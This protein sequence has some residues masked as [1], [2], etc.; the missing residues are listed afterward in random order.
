MKKNINKIIASLTLFLTPLI[1]KAAELPNP[2]KANSVP[3]LAR[4]VI[5]GL[6]GVA[7]AIALFYLV[8]G[9]I[10]WM[11]SQGNTDRIKKGKDT[12]VWAIF[13]LAAIF[14][15]YVVLD[16]LF[17]SLVQGASCS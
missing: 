8:W 16:F 15:S 5:Q 1:I 17:C 4:N 11:T 6:L 12:I 2:L 3:E 7:G 10:T 9:G 14:F 13:G